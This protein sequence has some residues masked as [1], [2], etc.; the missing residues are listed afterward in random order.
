MTIT[1]RVYKDIPGAPGLYKWDYEVNNVSIVSDPS[2]AYINGIADLWLGL[3]GGMEAG[4]PYGPANW[5][6]D[7]SPG[8]SFTMVRAYNLSG[9]DP[10]MN[11]WWGAIYALQPGQTMHFGFTTFPRQEA[12]LQPC[13]MDD[14]GN[15]IDW[16]TCA[17]ADKAA[18]VWPMIVVGSPEI[19]SMRKSPALPTQ[20]PRQ[21]AARP[22]RTPKAIVRPQD[23][24][25]CART[26]TGRI[27]IP[28]PA[29][30]QLQSF[31]W[32]ALQDDNPAHGMS[33]LYHDSV[34]GDWSED[35]LA[36]E[37]DTEVTDPA[38]MANST[39]TGIPQKNDPV[40]Y[41]GGT[42]PLITNIVLTRVDGSSDSALLRVTTDQGGLAFPD[43]AIQFSNG[44]ASL[45]F[46]SSVIAQQAL[47]AA[48]ANMDV[49]LTWSISLDSGV[50]WT[51]F[52]V[53]NHKIFV[54]LGQPMGFPGAG[55]V[56]AK[57]NVTAARINYVTNLLN[58]KSDQDSVVQ[59]LQVSVDSLF[60]RGNKTLYDLYGSDPWAALDSP[61]SGA[62]LDCWNRTAIGDVQV[63]MAG[64]NAT[65]A[66]AFP[67]TD[68]DATAQ[69]SRSSGSQVLGY[70]LSDGVTPNFFEAYLCLCQDN[71]ATEAYTF[72]P[73]YGPLFPWT[74]D[75]QGAPPS[76]NGQI[77]FRVIYTELLN[78]RTAPPTSGQQWWIL[79]D[80]SK[81]LVDGP[82]SFPVPIP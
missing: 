60:G 76:N 34:N 59:A 31:H 80:G 67:T 64:I 74:T 20:G 33:A 48:I 55:G 27:A 47:P 61:D 1:V 75:V 2:D 41:I 53:T 30:T 58:G 81:T 28:G 51:S 14:N 13:A 54:T 26:I 49:D 12:E 5:E 21:R 16:T 39:G 17:G 78:E 66:V 23:T 72:L 57:V 79:N 69:E 4:N 70:L 46:P 18:A 45:N 44:T 43:T 22:R 65:M 73:L 15:P 63:L 32:K 7:A 68:G 3:P 71:Q 56:N 37:G 19:S 11:N 42:K 38:W 35:A 52:A 62:P 9:P 50:T 6:V 77:P 40:A 82:V 25:G 36:D 10:A 29:L 24:S 8:A